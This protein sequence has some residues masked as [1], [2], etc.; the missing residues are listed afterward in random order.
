MLAPLDNGGVL[1]GFLVV[2]GWGG[3][4]DLFSVEHSPDGVAEI[5]YGP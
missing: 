1:L 5:E 4:S 2:M 3:D